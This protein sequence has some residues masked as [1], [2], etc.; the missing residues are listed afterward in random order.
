[1][2]TKA[3]FYILCGLLG[4][5]MLVYAF[6][7]AA[8]RVPV[9]SL[10]PTQSEKQ[11]KRQQR[12]HAVGY[13]GMGVLAVLESA[14]FFTQEVWILNLMSSVRNIL[15]L[16]LVLALSVTVYIRGYIPGDSFDD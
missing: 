11:I 6:L 7:V 12:L 8:G 3:I 16:Y 10:I 15:T 5:I 13:G 4:I 14:Y 9:F 2:K 1:M